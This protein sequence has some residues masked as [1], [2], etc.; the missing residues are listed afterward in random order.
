MELDADHGNN[1]SNKS[2]MSPS[3]DDHESQHSDD[4]HHQATLNGSAETDTEDDDES[5]AT[6]IELTEPTSTTAANC[7]NN[8]NSDFMP[9]GGTIAD[10]DGSTNGFGSQSEDDTEV[11]DNDTASNIESSNRCDPST[12]S[13]MHEIECD[14]IDTL[15]GSLPS[16]VPIFFLSLSLSL[17]MRSTLWPPPSSFSC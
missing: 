6:K 17:F 9:C 4:E 14:Q 8:S 7:N 5:T 2:T 16:F 13:S 3:V 10:E 12:P 15:K 1:S 11:A